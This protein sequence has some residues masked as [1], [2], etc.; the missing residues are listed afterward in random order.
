MSKIIQSLKSSQNAL[1]ESP[2]GSGKSLALLC[3]A[4]GWLEN[5]KEKNDQMRKPFRE[6]EAELMKEV[7]RVRQLDYS[8]HKVDQSTSKYFSAKQQEIIK[9]C[10]KNG[11]A[12]ES[13][14]CSFDIDILFSLRDGIYPLNAGPSI[15]PDE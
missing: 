10:P 9:F 13:D 5:E 2:T 14:M 4:L 7:F 6:K 1:L 8:Q 15:S 11:F 12:C 3:S